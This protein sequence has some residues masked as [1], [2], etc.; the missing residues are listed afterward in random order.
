MRYRTLGK[1]GLEVSELG[2]G[3]WGISGAAW[4]GAD[5]DE[6]VRALRVAIDHGVN[7]LDTAFVY[8]DGEA[9]PGL[10]DRGAFIY[11]RLR[12]QAYSPQRLGAWDRRV[13]AYLAGGRDV[14]L[15]FKHEDLAPAY[16]R[17]LRARLQ[18]SARDPNSAAL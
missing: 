4:I 11:L 1:T 17:R 8:G 3:A 18:T 2:Y 16:A 6:S 9:E 15:Y 12:R 14:F 5:D 13:R 7:F 10:L